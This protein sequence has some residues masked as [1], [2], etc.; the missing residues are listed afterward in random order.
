MGVSRDGVT[1]SV[2][3]GVPA[4]QQFIE[5]A[6]KTALARVKLT[7]GALRLAQTEYEKAVVEADSL[8]CGPSAIGH[9]AGRS[10][11]T[12]RGFL[13]RRKDAA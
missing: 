12:I 8:D 6:Q 2:T 11:S 10:E 13:R 4:A 1:F 3:G 5:S 9:S 7:S